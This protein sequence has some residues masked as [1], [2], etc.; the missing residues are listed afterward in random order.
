MLWIF[1]DSL[2]WN[3][4]I[5]NINTYIRESLTSLSPSQL[6]TLCLQMWFVRNTFWSGNGHLA[7]VS[8]EGAACL[9]DSYQSHWTS[10]IWCYCTLS[11]FCHMS[12]SAAQKIKSVYEIPL[13]EDKCRLVPGPLRIMSYVPFSFTNFILYNFAIYINTIS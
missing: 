1:L 10:W 13:R 5:V 9:Y 7:K 4:F 6:L 8:H 2:Y 3:M 11:K 12:H